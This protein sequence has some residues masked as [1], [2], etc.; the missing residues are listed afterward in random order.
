M[1]GLVFSTENVLQFDNNYIHFETFMYLQC[2][3]ASVL[4]AACCMEDWQKMRTF[5]LEP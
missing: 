5:L 3:F 2:M 4:Y 1:D